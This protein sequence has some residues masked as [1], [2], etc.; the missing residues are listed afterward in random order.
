MDLSTYPKE[1]EANEAWRKQLYNWCRGRPERQAEL[2][3]RCKDDLLFFINA[4]G[5]I[6]EQRKDLITGHVRLPF[7]TFDYQDKALGRMAAHLGRK[8]IIGD[9]SR[10]VGFTWMVLYLFLWRW[11]FYSLESFGVASRTEEYVDKAGSPD[12]HFWKLDFILRNLPSWLLPGGTNKQG[13]KTWKRRKKQLVNNE[14]Q[15]DIT[16]YATSGDIARGGRRLALLLDELAAYHYADG[17]GCWSA[18]AFATDCIFAVSTHQ[19]T[20]G[21]FADACRTAATN[22]R[23]FEHIVI[24]W[25]EDPR[26]NKGLCYVDP[27]KPEAGMSEWTVINRAGLMWSQWFEDKCVILHFDKREIAKELEGDPNAS[28]SGFF[29]GPLLEFAKNLG[30]RPPIRVGRLLYD[31]ETREPTKWIDDSNGNIKLWVDLVGDRPPQDSYA[32]GCDVSAGYGSSPSVIAMGSMTLGC[33]VA[34][35]VDAFRKPG[36]FAA[37]MVAMG[38]WFHNAKLIWECKGPG[39]SYINK[40]IAVEWEYLYVYFRRDNEGGLC[41]KP[42]AHVGWNPD[43]ES[44]KTL[45]EVFRDALGS[46]E[47]LERSESVIVEC[48]DYRYGKDGG[49][50]QAK[51]KETDDPTKAGTNHGDRVMASAMLWKIIKEGRQLAPA[52]SKP[53]LDLESPF[54]KEGSFAWFMAMEMKQKRQ[55][56][57]SGGLNL[58]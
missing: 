16:G 52:G 46:G 17:K 57:I 41:E 30:C 27:E 19:G 40:L 37:D 47:Y 4:F 43:R 3:Q 44:K 39:G 54:A 5:Y 42:T 33:K 36:F 38:K 32:A 58:G 18:A 15:S 12:S 51:S 26:K 56:E 25:W 49:V 10:D 48:R 55:L 23:L 29:S 9:K 28:G 7:I 35:F 50:E 8:H 21:A 24:R 45:M 22:P 31:R 34:E 1:R 20:V 14:L 53:A 6:A 11:L 2:R 13:P